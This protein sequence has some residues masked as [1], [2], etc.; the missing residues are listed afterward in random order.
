MNTALVGTAVL[1]ISFA[2]GWRSRLVL[3][4]QPDRLANR[5]LA[6][7]IGHPD[8]VITGIGGCTFVRC[9]W[10]WWR[11]HRVEGLRPLVD[12]CQL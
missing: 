2:A 9:K 11:R 12:I 6:G 4:Y 8:K 3:D 1:R 7:V 5:Y 10:R